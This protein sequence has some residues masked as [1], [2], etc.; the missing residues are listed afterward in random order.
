M[1]YSQKDFCFDVSCVTLCEIMFSSLMSKKRHFVCVMSKCTGQPM[2]QQKRKRGL[3]PIQ[4]WAPCT[5]ILTDIIGFDQMV[6]REDMYNWFWE[7]L[8]E[9]I[10]L[11]SWVSQVSARLTTVVKLEFKSTVFILINGFSDYKLR[12]VLDKKRLYSYFC[13]KINSF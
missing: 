11:S 5:I 13:F 12:G 3:Q 2:C 7:S 10:L 4:P 6:A 1:S 8:R 9:G